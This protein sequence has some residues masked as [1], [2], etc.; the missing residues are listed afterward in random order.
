MLMLC[1]ESSSGPL[2]AIACARYDINCVLRGKLPLL[3]CW[4]RLLCLC[5]LQIH[6]RHL[7]GGRARSY[8]GEI[9]N[10]RI[11]QVTYDR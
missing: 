1:T 8:M 7:V 5:P 9:P 3:S 4:W 2:C 6:L 11:Y 10:E